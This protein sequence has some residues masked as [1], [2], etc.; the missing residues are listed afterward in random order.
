M[1]EGSAESRIICGETDSPYV[2][3]AT[4]VCWLQRANLPSTFCMMGDG[5]DFALACAASECG[6][7]VNFYLG[8]GLNIEGPFPS[9]PF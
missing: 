7:C 1:P 8:M 9:G 4:A 2:S 6:S 5:Q 3:A